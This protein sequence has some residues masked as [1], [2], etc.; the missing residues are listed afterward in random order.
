[1]L[2]ISKILK[3]F[4]DTLKQNFN[5][6]VYGKETNKE[7]KM[8]CFSTEIVVNPMEKL[9]KN[10]VK[11]EITINCAYLMETVDQV[12]QYKIIEKMR[13]LFLN[14]L[15]VDKRTLHIKEFRQEYTG[16]LNDIL[17]FQIDIDVY[18]NIINKNKDHPITEVDLRLKRKEGGEIYE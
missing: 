3:A 4:N 8:P 12:E 13:E 14:Y 2:E 18:D 10:I 11:T 6:R 5:C 7:Y 17:E 15:V 1:M 16:E 9:N